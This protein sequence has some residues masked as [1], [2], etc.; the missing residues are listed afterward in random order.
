MGCPGTWV[1]GERLSR[2]GLVGLRKV[3]TPLVTP[4]D[5]ESCPPLYKT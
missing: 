3:M 1:D 4:D 5:L 2:A